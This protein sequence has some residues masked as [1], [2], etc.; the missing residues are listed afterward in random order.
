MN[1]DKLVPCLETCRKL[2]E[3]GIEF[4]ESYFVWIY[5]PTEPRRCMAVSRE[6]A[7]SWGYFDSDKIIIYPAPTL[8]ELLEW[9]PEMDY[10]IICILDKGYKEPFIVC[11]RNHNG[12][13]LSH[14]FAESAAQ[15]ALW[16]VQ[17][18][19]HIGDT[20]EMIKEG[21]NAK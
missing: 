6:R 19:Y 17:N 21:S 1:I 9:L 14:S 2:K 4:P 18:G 3:A 13:E 8:A 11:G 5:A 20:N 7:E 10:G 12:C 15:L 16:V